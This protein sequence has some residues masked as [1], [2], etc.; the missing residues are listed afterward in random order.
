MRVHVHTKQNYLEFNDYYYFHFNTHMQGVV[1]K[2]VFT[3]SIY[4]TRPK[5]VGHGY[6]FSIA[7]GPI[8]EVSPFLRGRTV[9]SE[10][11]GGRAIF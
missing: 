9:D 4:I 7:V 1:S 2:G 11:G 5:P 10:G 8:G 3:L 6:V